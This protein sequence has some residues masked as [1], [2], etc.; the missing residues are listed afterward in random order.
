MRSCNFKIK[1]SSMKETCTSNAINVIP[2]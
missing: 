1:D 2:M